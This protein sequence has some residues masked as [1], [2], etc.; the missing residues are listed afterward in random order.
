MSDVPVT[1]TNLSGREIVN[2]LADVIQERDSLRAELAE[3]DALAALLREARGDVAGE[4]RYLERAHG[5]DDS[6][7]ESTVVYQR[8]LL[9]RIDAALA[10]AKEQSRE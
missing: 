4:L 3:R 9:G 6:T 2:A 10:A 1:F 8:G 7:D 5:R